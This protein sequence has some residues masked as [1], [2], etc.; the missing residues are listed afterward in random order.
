METFLGCCVVSGIVSLIV[1]LALARFG[2]DK[3]LEQ[4]GRLLKKQNPG[5]EKL[6][7]KLAVVVE[8]RGTQ[9]R[10]ALREALKN[11]GWRAVEVDKCIAALGPRVEREELSG[12]V[13]EAIGRLA[14]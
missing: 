11:L 2:R 8:K 10:T 9:N 7:E 13:R 6:P 3:A 14:A 4:M 5:V 12:L 1:N